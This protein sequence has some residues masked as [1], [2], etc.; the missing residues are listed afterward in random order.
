MGTRDYKARPM[1]PP[2][3]S[4]TKENGTVYQINITDESQINKISKKRNRSRLNPH[5]ERTDNMDI[6]IPIT[7]YGAFYTSKD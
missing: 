2:S 3:R 1:D 5:I 4:E 7:V 6:D